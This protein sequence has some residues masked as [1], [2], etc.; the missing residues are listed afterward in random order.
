MKKCLFLIL[1]VAIAGAK[2]F[3]QAKPETLT[4]ANIVSLFKAGL[5]KSVVLTTI[6]NANTSFDTSTNG[7]IDLKQ[8][9]VPEDVIEAMINKTS[10]GTAVTGGMVPLTP[11]QLGSMPAQSG[12]G[13]LDPNNL[14]ALEPGIYY[15]DESAGQLIQMDGSVFSQMKMGSG[16]LTAISYGVAKT[17]AKAVLSS[18]QANFRISS[19][20]PTFYFI[21][22]HTQGGNFASQSSSGSWYSDATSPNEFLL[23][24]FKVKEKSREIVTGSYGTYSGFSGG[25]DDDNKVAF[26]SEKVSPGIYKVYLENVLTDREYAFMFAGTA[27][28]VQGGTTSQKA[29]D[30]SVQGNSV[31]SSDPRLNHPGGPPPPPNPLNLFKKKKADTTGNGN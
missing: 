11:A 13:A 14:G 12:G 17:K 19:K 28:T 18:A 29:F 25:I 7:I 1:F 30:F 5:S 24:R 23:V 26:R 4:N 10:K 31:Q 3:A 8:K 15:L 20:T 21:F 9:G 22:P 6:Q 27:Q 2:C 16:I